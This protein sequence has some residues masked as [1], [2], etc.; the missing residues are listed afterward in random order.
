MDMNLAEHPREKSPQK[1]FW[2]QVIAF[3]IVILAML[4][5]I[6]Y[7]NGLI[8]AANYSDELLNTS[9]TSEIENIQGVEQP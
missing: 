5:L 9:A 7:L 4:V 8:A 6:L 1:R 2:T 3:V